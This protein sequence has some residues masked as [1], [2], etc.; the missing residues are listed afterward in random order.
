MIFTGLL[1]DFYGTFVAKMRKLSTKRIKIATFPAKNIGLLGYKPPY[2][3]GKTSA[4]YP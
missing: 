1:R 3:V 4:L 2:F